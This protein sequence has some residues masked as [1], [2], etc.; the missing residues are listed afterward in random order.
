MGKRRKLKFGR[1]IEGDIIHT[2]QFHYWVEVLKHYPMMAVET[3]FESTGSSSS[4]EMGTTPS[5]SNDSNT[6]MTSDPSSSNTSPNDNGTDPKDADDPQIES[7]STSTRPNK[8]LRYGARLTVDEI[9]A[10]RIE[11]IHEAI[12][13]AKL[14]GRPE[15]IVEGIG[16]ATEQKD[17][18][19]LKKSTVQTA[20]PK[21][22][23]FLCIQD[24]VA[25]GRARLARLH[26]E[27]CADDSEEETESSEEESSSSDKQSSYEVTAL[28]HQVEK[29]HSWQPME[30]SY[31]EV[32]KRN[33]SW[34]AGHHAAA[35]SSASASV[36]NTSTTG[37]LFGDVVQRA[38]ERQMRLAISN[39]SKR[40]RKVCMCRYCIN[41][42]PHQTDKS[43]RF[44]SFLKSE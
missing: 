28:V 42:S 26:P 8:R 30:T 6:S 1:G 39:D 27:S 14:K 18:W 38:L 22:D 11:C 34:Q 43:K 9:F 7:S 36:E 41:S 4:T 40:L 15:H 29:H 31:T 35:A 2:P 23:Y 12:R 3:Q 24:V 19:R 20:L 17:T 5:I 10:K 13:V 25:A 37:N 21:S 33:Y 44:Q 16:Q 32:P